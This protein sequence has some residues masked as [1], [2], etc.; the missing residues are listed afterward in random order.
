M[1]VYIFTVV[2]RETDS[3]DEPFVV[4]S[5]PLIAGTVYVLYK[6]TAVLRETDSVGEPFVVDSTPPIAQCM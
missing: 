6:F 1:V 5:T 4:D 2:L 3:A